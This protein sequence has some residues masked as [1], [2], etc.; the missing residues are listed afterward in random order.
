MKRILV[1][2]AHSDD[3]IFGPGG[4][5]FRYSLEGAEIYTVIFSFGEKSHPLFKRRVTAKARVKEAQEVN[6]MLKGKDLIFLGLKDGQ[7]Q[8]EIPEKNTEERL[9]RLI[10]KFRPDRILT[11][12]PDDP[13]LDHRVVYNC[14]LSAAEKHNFKGEIFC[15]DVWTLFNLK[16][17]NLPKMYI[18]TSQ[19]FHKKVEALKMFK[20]QKMSFLILIF[21][22]FL[23]DFVNGLKSHSRYAEVFY[24]AF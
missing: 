6:V 3:Q 23:R 2:C 19:F 9:L 16:K 11:H 21:P 7:F 18:D 14:V 8:K 1:V 20:S 10:R 13:H 22:T 24:K 4:T 15:F 12:S 5:L 17:S